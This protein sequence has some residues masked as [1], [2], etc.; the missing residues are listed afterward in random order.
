MDPTRTYIFKEIGNHTIYYSF[1]SFSKNS[2]L[3]KDEGNGIFNGMENLIYAEFTD[4][5]DDDK[6][7]DVRFYEMFKN[8]IN[9][10]SVDL[11]KIELDYKSGGSYDNG[12]NYSS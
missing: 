7:P 10:K 4:D 2:L 1:N 11:S 9:L 3:S 5:N 12:N 6:Y 8:C